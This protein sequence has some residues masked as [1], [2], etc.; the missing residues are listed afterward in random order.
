MFFSL[1]RVTMP[2]CFESFLWSYDNIRDALNLVQ[3]LP[4]LVH[5]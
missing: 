5:L 1:L 3:L 4:W 2:A